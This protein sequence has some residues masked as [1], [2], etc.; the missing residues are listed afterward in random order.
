M[1][2]CFDTPSF[3]F[4]IRARPIMGIKIQI[5][6]RMASGFNG[7]HG[8]I[9]NIMAR[10]QGSLFWLI[11]I[12]I[13]WCKHSQQ[14]SRPRNT[15]YSKTNLKSS[16][17]KSKTENHLTVRFKLPFWSK[18]TPCITRNLW[19]SESSA[20]TQGITLH[21]SHGFHFFSKLQSYI[22]AFLTLFVDSIMFTG[23]IQSFPCDLIWE[24]CFK[25]KITISDF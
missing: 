20:I 24:W 11:L 25:S 12:H 10:L 4:Q 19:Q 23:S 9:Q 16:R 15:P 7:V 17:E 13:Q 1:L 22:H 2:N 14:N 21:N 8:I 3:T 6:T 18:Y 5:F